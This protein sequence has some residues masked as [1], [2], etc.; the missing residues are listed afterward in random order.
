MGRH[1]GQVSL[2]RRSQLARHLG[3]CPGD[4]GDAALDGDDSLVVEVVHVRDGAHCYP[5]LG[6]LQS[7]IVRNNL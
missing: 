5:S 6:V 1:G 4:V 3:L 2:I 7:T